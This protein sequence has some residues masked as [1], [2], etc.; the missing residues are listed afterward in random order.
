M[1]IK[2]KIRQIGMLA[3]VAQTVPVTP[4]L[5]IVGG[6]TLRSLFERIVLWVLAIAGMIAVLFL[7]YG[8]FLYLT[9]GGD[10][11]RVT[12]AKTTIIN[13]VIGIIVIALAFAIF[14]AVTDVLGNL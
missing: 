2:E 6:I 11:E 5:P 13:A 3:A 14:F 9:A 1:N 4:P 8:G 7:I 10:A 12:K